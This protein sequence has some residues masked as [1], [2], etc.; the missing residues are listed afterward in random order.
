MT[1]RLFS[2]CNVL[3]NLSQC[4]HYSR[5][6]GHSE[7]LLASHEAQS[8]FTKWPRSSRRRWFFCIW[9]P[10]GI[11]GGL[12]FG[13]PYQVPWQS[14][15]L[16]LV[17]GYK[18]TH[19][20]QY[21]ILLGSKHLKYIRVQSH[22]FWGRIQTC[23]QQK[24]SFKK[25]SHLKCDCWWKNLVVFPLFALFL[26]LSDCIFLKWLHILCQRLLL[27]SLFQ[28]RETMTGII[29]WGWPL[30]MVYE[31][32]YGKSFSI[33]LET[34]KFGS[35]M[36]RLKEMWDSSTMQEKLEPLDEWTFFT[37]SK[38]YMHFNVAVLHCKS[39]V[40]SQ[41]DYV[42][43]GLRSKDPVS[44]NTLFMVNWFMWT[45]KIFQKKIII[46]NIVGQAVSWHVW[47]Q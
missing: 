25:K 32:K 18:V 47:Q 22:G 44:K 39:N 29:M 41:S 10:L 31:Q 8:Q 11:D 3:F 35:F 26:S 16:Q 36:P 7:Y 30:G 5:L 15:L 19:S 14:I 13:G 27:M 33:A 23:T 40:G 42:I 4:K 43:C 37:R 1:T 2:V 6:Y 46:P 28:C 21:C 34:L 12:Y 38:Q 24:H 45:W 17:C 9:S 20:E